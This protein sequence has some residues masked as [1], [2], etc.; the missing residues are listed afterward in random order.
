MDSQI[1]YTKSPP[2]LGEP[3]P[4]TDFEKLKEKE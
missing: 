1:I 4:D 2:I 3:D